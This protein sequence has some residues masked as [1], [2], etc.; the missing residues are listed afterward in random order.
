MRMQIV[1]SRISASDVGRVSKYLS[2]PIVRLSADGSLMLWIDSDDAGGRTLLRSTADG[3][4]VQRNWSGQPTDAYLAA[5]GRHVILKREVARREAAGPTFRSLISV[6]P[7]DK[8]NGREEPIAQDTAGVKAFLPIGAGGPGRD[9]LYFMQR[10]DDGSSDL[11]R[12]R[13]VAGALPELIGP[14]EA[15]YIQ[16]LLDP[17]ER[18]AARITRHD[19]AGARVV[20][21][22][23]GDVATCKPLMTLA[24]GEEFITENSNVTVD[25]LWVMSNR[26]RPYR[27]LVRID[28]DTGAEEVVH[29]APD[30]DVASFWIDPRTGKPGLVSV[31]GK[32]GVRVFDPALENLL[33][34]LG[35]KPETAVK[36]LA[37]DRA[38]RWLVVSMWHPAMGFQPFLIDREAQIAERLPKPGE[39]S[40]QS[41]KLIVSWGRMPPTTLARVKVRDGL[42]LPVVVTVPADHKGGPLPTVVRARSFMNHTFDLDHDVGAKFLAERGYAVVSVNARGAAG[43][44]KALLAAGAGQYATGAID[45]LED[46]AKWA[47]AQG[48]AAPDRL[49]VYGEVHGGYGALVAIGRGESPFKVAVAISPVSDLVDVFDRQADAGSWYALRLRQFYGWQDGADNRRTL[50]EA[51]PINWVPRLERPLLIAPRPTDDPPQ[52]MQSERLVAALRAAGRDPT[53]PPSTDR[54]AR[55]LDGGEGAFWRQ[56]EVFLGG[57]LG[58]QVHNHE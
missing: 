23:A 39:R 46:V 52:R 9:W 48:I 22:C 36:V 32:A 56:L 15:R 10:R 13:T 5:N 8:E 51:S 44:G 47:V 42:E 20:E 49:A 55:R 31:F 45:D 27:A 34:R 43:F 1:A 54:F 25:A 30:A 33:N 17:A 24:P 38:G 53:P 40:G 50:L 57:H 35:R 4:T 41:T 19:R 3:S 2:A 21:K 37:S 6:A 7:L 11:Y 58:G 18:I 28:R 29:A 14:S 12:V 26:N 16:W